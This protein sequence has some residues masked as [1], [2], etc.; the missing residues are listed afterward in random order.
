MIRLILTLFI[1][2]YS[3]YASAGGRF[4]SGYPCSD[5]V[6]TCVSSG[7]REVQGFKVSRPCWE[8]SYEKDFVL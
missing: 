2:V 8:Y 1:V 4:N 7:E 6:R 3:F 5:A